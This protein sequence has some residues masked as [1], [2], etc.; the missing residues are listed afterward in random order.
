[1]I[2]FSGFYRDIADSQ[3]SILLESLPAKIGNWQRENNN[4]S[5]PKW[6]KVLAKLNYPTPDQLDLKDS[7]S[8]GSGA[9]L[10]AGQ[11]EKLENLLQ[12]LHPWR[13]GPFDIHGIHIDTEWRSDWKWERIAP[14]IS[15]LQSRT[16]L[17]VGCGSGYHMWR[18]FGA[19]ARM[20]VG[21]DP[22][23]LF[24]CQFEAVKKLAGSEYPVHLLPLGI[25]E[26]PAS[27]A[28]DTVFS[29]GVLYH[30]K[31]PIDHLLQLHD[32]LRD[33][34]ELVLETLVIDGDEQAVLVPED[35]YGKMN[36][37]WFIPS[38]AALER[39]LRR[40]DFKDIRCVNLDVTSLAEQRSTPW[41]RNESLVD[42][43]DPNNV[44]YTVEG[45]PAP[46]RA[47]II[48]VK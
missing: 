7:V 47:T 45:Y 27:E 10:S 17:D 24:L 4:G 8:I 14:H 20:V 23:P 46:K 11:R 38:V 31:S 29:M 30:R 5:L 39:W 41:M 16:V 15:P 43:L 32:Q 33:G 18:M 37:V 42:Y 35:R 34:G 13:K 44:D 28:F 40:C 48:A 1:M 9:Q 3:L 19:G 21:I 2:S 12:L 6:G 25:E 36:N 26:M 22:S